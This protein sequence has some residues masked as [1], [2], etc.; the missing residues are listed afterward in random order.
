M[1]SAY[2]LDSKLSGSGNKHLRT[3]W[4]YATTQFTTGGWCCCSGSRLP[5]RYGGLPDNPALHLNGCW[6]SEWK[7]LGDRWGMHQATPCAQRLQD[8]WSWIHKC[9]LVGDWGTTSIW[10]LGH[11]RTMRQPY[12]WRSFGRCGR[13]VRW[14]GDWTVRSEEHTSELQSQ[15]NL[16]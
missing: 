12:G 15:S 16:V 3:Y 11:I 1:R 2:F 9:I 6:W 10:S 13:R 8:S 4:R 14:R 7:G 5:G